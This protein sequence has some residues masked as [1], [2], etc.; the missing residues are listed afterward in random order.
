MV[1]FK[2]NK[3]LFDKVIPE[4]NGSTGA[5]RKITIYGVTAYTD[6]ENVPIQISSS[7]LGAAQATINVNNLGAIPVK[8]LD[9][10]G[11]MMNVE[12][13]WTV[14]NQIYTVVYK[15]G[16]FVLVTQNQT[17]SGDDN[18]YIIETLN[19]LVSLTSSST[20]TDILHAF[21]DDTSAFLN[22]II[23]GILLIAQDT[24]N[25]IYINYILDFN[26]NVLEDFILEFIHKGDYYKQTF[27]TDSNMNIVSV[28][29]I[30]S[31]VESPSVTVEDTL[32]S[33]SHVNPPSVHAVNDAIGQIDT[34]LN[35]ILGN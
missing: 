31:S 33:D 9:S 10:D 17:N 7:L 30:K 32:T 8:A 2:G 15:S 21:N 1:I 3:R 28:N 27:T 16:V 12:A 4:D 5:A 14:P 25:E 26:N 18:F 22:S 13:N 34:L 11:I 35:Q 20:Q 19:N 29:V 24:T 6:I 23:E